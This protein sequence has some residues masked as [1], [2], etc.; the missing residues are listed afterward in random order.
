MSDSRTKNS[1]GEAVLLH[2]QGVTGLTFEMMNA[3]SRKVQVLPERGRVG[4]ERVA[5]ETLRPLRGALIELVPA[6][7]SQGHGQH[8]TGRVA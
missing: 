2:L 6:T 5:T 8:G 4:S 3:P 1:G 7:A